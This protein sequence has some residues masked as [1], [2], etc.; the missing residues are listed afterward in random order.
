MMRLGARRLMSDTAAVEVPAKLF[1]I[2]ARYASAAFVAASKANVL[3]KVESELLAL[4]D[5]LAKNATLA[6][7][8]ANPT[9]SRDKKA[10]A[11]EKLFA[12]SSHV[13][14]N[15]L[16]TLAS[17]ARLGEVG[18]VIDAYATLMKAQRGEVD[19]VITSAIELDKT[20]VGA[21]EKA[22]KSHLK[23]G[24]KVKVSTTVNPSLLGGFTV[25]LGDKYLDLSA[26]SKIN[27]I[28]RSL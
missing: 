17:N 1:G 9:I 28:Q 16:E 23:K 4:K 2:H 22:L 7:F 11:I 8:V 18:K 10:E 15:M 26:A 5:V 12:D 25:Q 3:P 6:S 27:A 14:K 13:T 19:A 21:I 24:E 20:Q